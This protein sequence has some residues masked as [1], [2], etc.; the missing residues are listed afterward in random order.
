[1]FWVSDTWSSERYWDRAWLQRGDDSETLE[2]R[3]RDSG[4]KMIDVNA[5]WAGVPN[6]TFLSS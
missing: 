1:V 4:K 6:T 3:N 2:E 5:R